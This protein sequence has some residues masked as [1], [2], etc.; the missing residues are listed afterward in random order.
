MSGA[1]PRERSDRRDLLW[2]TRNF[3][4]R[5]NIHSTYKRGYT[6][7]RK[8]TE[9]SLVYPKSAPALLLVKT[10]NSLHVFPRSTPQRAT[11]T[12]ATL[13]M[14]RQTGCGV[15][16]LFF[17]RANARPP[18]AKG[19]PATRVGDCFNA[20]LYN[21]SV[22]HSR[23]T[24]LCTREAFSPVDSWLNSPLNPKFPPRLLCSH[25]PNAFKF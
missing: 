19:A 18:C 10:R 20:W 15:Q 14:T 1:K 12:F 11:G 9:N 4:T 6:H 22:T 5:C 13:R 7:P 2:R 16:I 23:A 17:W 24:S 25:S 3:L 8:A 21:P